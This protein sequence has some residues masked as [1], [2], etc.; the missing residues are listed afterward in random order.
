MFVLYLVCVPH[1]SGA[2]NTH[3][4]TQGNE[5]HVTHEDHP[6]RGF[7][8]TS[9]RGS[10]TCACCQGHLHSKREPADA[11]AEVDVGN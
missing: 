4:Q 10:Q 5:S 1:P 3:T 11:G 8:K 6:L 9:L 7:P 2:A